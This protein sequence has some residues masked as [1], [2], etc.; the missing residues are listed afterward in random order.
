MKKIASIINCTVDDNKIAKRF[1]N[2]IQEIL[3]DMEH[4]IKASIEKE[5]C[6]KEVISQLSVNNQEREQEE[7]NVNDNQ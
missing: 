1:L 4:D 6:Q 7:I 5:E 3:Y 2:G